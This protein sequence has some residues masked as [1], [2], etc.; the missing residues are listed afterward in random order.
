MPRHT[1]FLHYMHLPGP[2][3]PPCL[4]PFYSVFQ[5]KLYDFK[6]HLPAYLFMKKFQ[7]NTKMFAKAVQFFQLRKL[8]DMST[9][10][11]HNVL[12]AS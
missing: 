6:R 12:E 5:N 10:S 2:P 11:L 8:F 9:V 4:T 1:S 7:K 3:P